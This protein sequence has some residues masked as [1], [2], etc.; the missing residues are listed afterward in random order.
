VERPLPKVKEHF[1]LVKI[2]VAPMCTEYKAYEHG[3][4]GDALGHEAAGEVV[5]IPRPGRVKIG[6]RVW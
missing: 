2:E 1:A 6:D 5:E 3:W 4:T